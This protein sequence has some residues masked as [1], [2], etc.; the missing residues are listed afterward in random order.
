MKSKNSYIVRAHQTAEVEKVKRAE[1]EILA[2]KAS[3]K[4][5][6]SNLKLASKVAKL[7]KK[8][9]KTAKKK[10]KIILKEIKRTAKKTK[11][12]ITAVV[13]RRHTAS[14]ASARKARR[15]P[16]A[17][18][19]LSPPALMP[20]AKQARAETP[21]KAVARKLPDG[22]GN[23]SFPMQTNEAEASASI[24]P[25]KNFQTPTAAAS[26]ISPVFN[27]SDSSAPRV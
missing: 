3:A 9:F 11:Q 8:R 25:T 2:A 5:A 19:H 4:R 22:T 27:P 26:P 10:L 17:S 1:H 18:L 12:K 20:R 14:V 6:K 21:Q 15:R 23:K 16:T 24:H 7:A 13:K